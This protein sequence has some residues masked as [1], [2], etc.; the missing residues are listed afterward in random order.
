MSFKKESKDESNH[1]WELTRFATDITKH[2]IGL[3]GKLFS[4]F[5]RNYNPEYIKSFADRRWT[6]DK[7]NNL[8]TKLGFTLEKVLA[9]DYRYVNG[10]KREHKFGYRKHILMKKY[11]D[12]GLTEDMTEY[13]MTQKL[14]FYRIWDCGLLKY[15]WE[16]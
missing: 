5:I 14:G 11:P 10:D 8:Y 13:E 2:C 3:G 9:P 16:K 7:D 12:A 15:I 6:L 4:Y 1:N